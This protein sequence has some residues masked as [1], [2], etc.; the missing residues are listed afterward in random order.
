MKT[1]KEMLDDSEGTIVATLD[2]SEERSGL[3]TTTSVIAT[4]AEWACQN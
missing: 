2:L 4:H 3:A 1:V